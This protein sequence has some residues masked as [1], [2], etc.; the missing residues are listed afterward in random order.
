MFYKIGKYK[1]KLVTEIILEKDKSGFIKKFF[2]KNR[3]KNIKDIPLHKY[4]EGPFC[5]FKIPVKHKN[6]NGVYLLFV[7]NEL[8]YVGICVDLY[9]RFNSGYGNISP[10]NCFIKGQ[11]TNCKINSKIL[12]EIE[13]S[14]SV[15]LF[16]LKTDKVTAIED[17]IISRFDPEWNDKKIGN[18]NLVKSAERGFLKMKSKYIKL[19]EYL[20]NYSISISYKEIEKIIGDKLLKSAY[21]H[22][23]WWSNSGYEHAKAWTDAGWKVEGVKL[24]EYITFRK[25]S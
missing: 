15:Y 1:F 23:A 16:F 19:K 8:K 25:I 11:S 17:M 20:K 24:G 9:Y 14:N 7:N 22:R 2:P 5:S 4:G 13:N 6:E 3:Y 21:V 10:R 12:K 18:L